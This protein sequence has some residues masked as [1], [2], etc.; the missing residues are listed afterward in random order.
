MDVSLESKLLVCCELLVASPLHH[1]SSPHK[2]C[3]DS[4]V[5]CSEHILCQFSSLIL[6]IVF[7]SGN[8]TP[9]LEWPACVC[10]VNP[11]RPFKPQNSHDN[12][13]AC[14][15]G[16]MCSVHRY[17]TVSENSS[18]LSSFCPTRLVDHQPFSPDHK[19]LQKS[20]MC[21]GHF[22]PPPAHTHTYTCA[23]LWAVVA[24][25]F[26]E[27]TERTER[28]VTHSLSHSLPPHLIHP[29]LFSPPHPFFLSLL[30][31]GWL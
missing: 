31:I 5:C 24:F 23:W 1:G 6:L 2:L 13:S 27:L 18:P 20:V 19:M 21:S 26:Q 8:T 17:F 10:P 4:A 30:S 28:T 22:V 9:F 14:S 7:I 25:E 16:R 12:L 29:H 3:A 11:V 15:R